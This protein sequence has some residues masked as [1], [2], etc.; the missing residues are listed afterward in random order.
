M[1]KNI[2]NSV[3][4]DESEVDPES[5]E[6]EQSSS[7]GEH[8]QNENRY[9]RA[10]PRNEYKSPRRSRKLQ[11]KHTENVAE[12]YKRPGLTANTPLP[13]KLQLAEETKGNRG[14]GDDSQ[15][16]IAC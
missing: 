10:S 16:D 5:S 14:Q 2:D 13:N 4:S 11:Y 12:M 9:V 15:N 7:S 3:K 8:N 6:N 1:I